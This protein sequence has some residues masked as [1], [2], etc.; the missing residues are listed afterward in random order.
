MKALDE[1]KAY[2]KHLREDGIM[3]ISMHTTGIVLAELKK[4][5]GVA[6][7]DKL[8][9]DGVEMLTFLKPR[10]ELLLKA[11]LYAGTRWN[12]DMSELDVETLF[13]A[14]PDD[15]MMS[16]IPLIVDSHMDDHD[17]PDPK[18]EWTYV[19]F[20]ARNR[21]IKMLGFDELA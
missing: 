2:L 6:D 11:R 7:A 1:L 9:V 15:E 8:V 12:V 5:A 18:D 21:S 4:Q 14:V 19:D 17:M 20:R 3:P 16:L 13:G 10:D